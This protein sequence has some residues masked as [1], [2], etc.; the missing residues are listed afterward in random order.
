MKLNKLLAM[1]LASLTIG[2]A[3]AAS[4]QQVTPQSS[5][6][7]RAEVLADLEIWRESGMADLDRGHATPP[8]YSARYQ[9]A[10]AE[11]ERLRASPQFATLVNRIASAHGWDIHQPAS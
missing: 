5:M 1:L 4:A 3:G 10:K 6:L 11:Y 2:L 8:F 7:T 9:H